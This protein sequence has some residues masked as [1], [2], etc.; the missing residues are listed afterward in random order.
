MTQ[1]VLGSEGSKATIMKHL[2]DGPSGKY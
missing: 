2:S 1:T